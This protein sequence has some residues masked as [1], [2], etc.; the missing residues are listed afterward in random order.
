VP[1][2]LKSILAPKPAVNDVPADKLALALEQ[3]DEQLHGYAFKLERMAGSAQLV[4]LDVQI[5][6]FKPD[7]FRHRITFLL[8]V[9][10]WVSRGRMTAS[11]PSTPSMRNRNSRVSRR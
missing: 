7:W 6:F 5:K 4:S 8:V 1:G 9:N 2:V 11:L 3:Q 10:L